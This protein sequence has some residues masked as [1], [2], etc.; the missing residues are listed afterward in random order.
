VLFENARVRS[1]PLPVPNVERLC[2]R[3]TGVVTEIGV[4][5]RSRT[6]PSIFGNVFE[7]PPALHSVIPR[8]CSFQP[9]AEDNAKRFNV[10]T[11]RES[12]LRAVLEPPRFV[13]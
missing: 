12:A 5:F 13:D 2:L 7:L 9:M 10:N 1:G 3:S 11:P 8:S 6:A 4:I